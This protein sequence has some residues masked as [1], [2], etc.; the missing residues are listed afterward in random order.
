[1]RIRRLISGVGVISLSLITNLTFSVAPTLAS[2]ITSAPAKWTHL[3]AQS[4][5]SVS[6]LNV[7]ESVKPAIQAAIDVWSENFT[8]TVP[9]NVV[10]NWSKQ[11]N[12]GLLATATP[13]KFFNHF[14]GAPDQNLWYAAPLANALAGKDLDPTKPEIS[15]KINSTVASTFYLGTDGNCPPNQYDLESILIHEIAHGLGYISN[16]DYDSYFEYGSIEQPTPF[17]AYA[18]LPDGRRL[19]DVPSPSSE[20][21]KVLRKP[22]YWSG[23][24]GINANNGVKP[25]LY[26]PA[27][28][29]PGSSV[30]HL[31]E[32]T[33]AK[34]GAD[35]IMTPNM[36]TGEVFH[37]PGPLLLAMFADMRLKP[38]AGVSTEKPTA[39]RNVRALVNDKS[40]VLYFDPP[41]N[42]RI[43]QVRT[44]TIKINQTGTE[45][46]AATSPVVVPHLINGVSYTFTVTAKN[47][48]GV[49]EPVLSNAV[50]PQPSWPSVI[51]DGAASA[52]Y[53]ASLTFRSKP[54]IIYSDSLRQQLKMATWDGKKWQRT[55]IDGNSTSG[56]RTSNDV[57]GSVSACISKSGKNEILNV[58][59]SDLT[60]KDLRYANYDGKKWNFEIVDGNGAK[61][62]QA[63]DTDRTRTAGDVSV[64]NACA[65]TP[66][67]L[68]VF[69]RDESQ[70]LL[71][72]AVRNGNSWRYEVID[73]DKTTDGRTTGD[74]GFHIAALAIGNKVTLLYDSV[75]AVNLDHQP[76]RGELRMATRSTAY[77]ED[78]VHSTLDASQNAIALTGI[79]ISLYQVG[80]TIY[81]GWLAGS[82]ISVPAAD[83]VRWSVLGSNTEPQSA[84]TE[85]FGAPQGPTTL[86]SNRMIFG[87]GNR[88]CSINK[89]DR[90][91][92]LVTTSLVKD[93]VRAAWIT[94][95][96]AKYAV[97]GVNGK[98]M[99][100]KLL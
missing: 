66:A 31:D 19:M 82:G 30:S 38:S 52:N 81:A 71:L 86:D 83:Q 73:G 36:A 97:L 12:A 53:L 2:S 14:P 8:S 100:Y 46:T 40:A 74:V 43:A 67:G 17:D 64:S 99:A 94:F 25:L 37:S 61:V 24:N 59:Y 90:V 39:P 84:T 62:L 15:I 42:A 16:N 96:G 13:G 35:A 95:G 22:L 27:T 56:G 23:Q 29:D 77:P 51:I 91:I 72:G 89:T 5:F 79:S 48:L 93:A 54:V 55:I 50:I 10:A 21:G 49:S 65:A 70:G 6:Y 33:F 60:N 88:L 76:L 98:L 11:T 7:P 18:Q 4:T 9:I 20:L 34:A 28:F 26:T 1:M 69:Y 75:V 45:M 92:R 44:Y 80:S 85:L 32:A 41:A 63:S 87:C 68:Q 3:N 78:W 58:F 57:S 47:E